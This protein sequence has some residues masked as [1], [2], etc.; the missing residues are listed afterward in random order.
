MDPNERLLKAAVEIR[1]NQQ[2]VWLGYLSPQLVLCTLAHSNPGDD[3]PEWV[4]KNRNV[5]LTV[6]AKRDNETGKFLHPYGTKPRLLLAWLITEAVRKR[7]RTILLGNSFDELMRNIGL[8]PRTGGGK[9]SDR[10]LFLDQM[11][12]LSRAIISYE[13]NRDGRLQWTD[14]QVAPRGMVW[15][16]LTTPINGPGLF[17]NKIELGEIFFEMV[18]KKPVPIDLRITTALRR[19]P[20]AQDLYHWLTYC[21]EMYGKVR[22]LPIRWEDLHRQLGGEYG[23]IRDFRG[24]VKQA[25][26][27]VQTLYSGVKVKTDDTHI[28][29]LK[30]SRASVFFP[31]WRKREREDGVD[32]PLV[33][34]L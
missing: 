34:Q 8:D 11:V 3:V 17:E 25:L 32:G 5:T 33:V 26:A 30:G 14:M 23:Q 2:D 20:L 18:I 1:T 31:Q 13:D 19:S 6:R 16:G 7:E 22:H 4:R 9:R 24:A 21:A 29:I 12:R 10:A 27:K 15:W 28:T